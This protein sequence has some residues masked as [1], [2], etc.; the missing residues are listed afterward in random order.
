MV[1]LN[2]CQSSL[3]GLFSM[4]YPNWWINKYYIMWEK[5]SRISSM[6]TLAFFFFRILCIFHSGVRHVWGSLQLICLC[7][8][9]VFL[10][11]SLLSDA[12]H[13]F[14]VRELWMTQSAGGP[15]SSFQPIIQMEGAIHTGSLQ[16]PLLPPCSP[17]QVCAVSRASYLS[18]TSHGSQIV[19]CCRGSETWKRMS[20]AALP[21]QQKVS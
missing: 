11:R 4:Y 21:T 6:S 20:S 10:P 15:H 12:G 3:L 2:L 5:V 9:S 8:F 19:I 7:S 16:V 1:S 13:N 18:L 17:G 14:H